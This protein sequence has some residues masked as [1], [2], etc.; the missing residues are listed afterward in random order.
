MEFASHRDEKEIMDLYRA[1]IDK[2][3]TTS[4]RLGWRIDT[5]PDAAFVKEAVENREMCILKEQD[6]IIATAVLN[7]TVNSEYDAI[8][9]EISGPK[10]KIATIHALAVA[11]DKQGTKLSYRMLKELEDH[12]R[13]EGNLAIHIDVI[14]TNIPAYKLYTRNG[15]KEV[16][17]IRMFYEVVG[18]REFW[19]LEHVL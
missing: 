13:K 7:H 16:D 8:A 9:W 6:R 19:M 15:Y 3:N 4:V 17:R 5:Y 1:V 18:V 14:D 10:E 11:P 12:C 2:V